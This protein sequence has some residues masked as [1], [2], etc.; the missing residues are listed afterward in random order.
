MFL[1]P[2]RTANLY[3]MFKFLKLYKLVRCLNK[4]PNDLW[5]TWSQQEIKDLWHI[6]SIYQSISFA[7]SQIGL[8]RTVGEADLAREA[9][10]AREANLAREANIAREADLSVCQLC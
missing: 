3:K 6:W 1:T 7:K 9:N 8:S 2:S 4:K 5:H 10:R